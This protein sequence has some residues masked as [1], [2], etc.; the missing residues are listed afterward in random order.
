[1]NET[2]HSSVLVV[3]VDVSRDEVVTPFSGCGSGGLLIEVFETVVDIDELSSAK[4]SENI[5]T[6]E[7]IS[8]INAKVEKFLSVLIAYD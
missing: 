5:R 7:T 4:Q 6:R 3:G 8:K 2:G 1:M